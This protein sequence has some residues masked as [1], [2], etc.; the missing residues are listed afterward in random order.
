MQVSAHGTGSK[1]PT[2]DEMIVR[3]KIATP[4][5]GLLE[6]NSDSE[7]LF[8]M[9]KVGLGSLGVVIELTLKCVPL[10]RLK[11]EVSVFNRETIIE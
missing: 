2:V 5:K 6:L 4:N 7:G 11:E 8:E 3:M 1:L 9:A 10:Y